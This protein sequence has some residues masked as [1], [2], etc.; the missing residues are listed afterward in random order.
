PVILVSLFRAIDI[1]MNASLWVQALAGFLVVVVALLRNRLP[2]LPKVWFL[3]SLPL[4]LGIVGVFSFGLI[5]GSVMLLITA[6]IIA[7]TL[8]GTRS[9]FLVV[10]FSAL[11]LVA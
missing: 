11:C 1:G 7:A 10:A 3:V 5:D 6:V 9:G 4:V 8:A 2:Y